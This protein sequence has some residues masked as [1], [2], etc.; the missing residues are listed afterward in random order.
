VISSPSRKK[1]EPRQPQ[2]TARQRRTEAYRL[3]WS[4][5]RRV[6]RKQDRGLRGSEFVAALERA[7]AVTSDPIFADALRAA[8]Q[9]GLDREFERNATR[10][11]SEMFGDPLAGHLVQVRFL[12]RRGKMENGQRRRLSVREACECVTAES[13][14]HSS[15][16][17]TAVERLRQEFL[18]HPPSGNVP[19]LDLGTGMMSLHTR[20][21]AEQEFG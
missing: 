3:E 18:A 17:E 15:S 10:L 1:P 6:V 7:G 2:Q 16:F 12:V 9:Y 11:Q 14:L 8:R 13:G 5:N 19:L 20:R 4:K 21:I